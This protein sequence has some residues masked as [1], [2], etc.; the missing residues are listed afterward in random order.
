[1]QRPT[2]SREPSQTFKRENPGHKSS[3]TLLFSPFLSSLDTSVCL[4]APKRLVRD[5]RSKNFLH[6]SCSSMSPLSSLKITA[7]LES[8]LVLYTPRS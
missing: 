3:F 1:M 6:Q 5:L 7:P 4:R 2:P 8:I